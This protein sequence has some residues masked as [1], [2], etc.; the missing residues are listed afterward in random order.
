MSSARQ[1]VD[2]ATA[3]A[4]SSS[5]SEQA[6]ADKSEEAFDESLIGNAAF[7]QDAARRALGLNSADAASPATVKAALALAFSGDLTAA[8]RLA[9]QI[10][11]EWPQGSVQDF[12]LPCI[13]AAIAIRQS[14]PADAIRM[15]VTPSRY[16]LAAGNVFA[17]YIRGL[18]YLQAGEGQQASAEFGRIIGHPGIVGISLIVPLAR[19]QLARAQ[20]MMGDKAA[21]RK[22]YQDFLT[23]WKDADH[24]IPIYQQAKAEYAKLN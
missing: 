13:R 5:W 11:Q 22:S 1:L 12:D 2:H 19:V 14:K 6:A 24:D 21:A 4:Q 23:L 15:L 16:E 18:A 9:E 7:A 8:E 3:V 10:S 17:S 20:V